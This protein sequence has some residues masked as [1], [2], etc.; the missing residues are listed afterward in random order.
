M[1]KTKLLGKEM[2]AEYH[3]LKSFKQTRLWSGHKGELSD[4]LKKI[5]NLT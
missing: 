1:F 4:L 3:F 5:W 2:N